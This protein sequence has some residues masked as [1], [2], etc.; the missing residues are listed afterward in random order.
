MGRLWTDN[1]LKELKVLVESGKS[2]KYLA[3]YFDRTETAI[4]LKVNRLGL[5]IQSKGRIWRQSEIKSFSND[6]LDGSVSKN[7]LIKKYNRSFPAL[8][9]KA[10]ELGLGAR[11]HNDE[12]LSINEICDE[13]NVSND[14]VS[15][16]LKLGLKYRKNRS[17]KTKYLISQDD[18]LEFLK[19]HQDLFNA[20]LI[21]N[22]LFVTEP[23]WLKEKRKKDAEFYA[24][25]LRNEYTDNDD[26]TIILLFKCGKSNK[27][28]AVDMKRTENAIAERLRMLGYSRHHWNDYEI[29]ILKENSRFMTLKELSRL[30]PLRSEKGIINKC[31]LLDLPYHLVKERCEIRVK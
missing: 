22:Y 2:R 20:S 6:W 14:R 10:F 1:E 29:D 11:P 24:T 15:H 12:F 26:K 8:K 23:N 9:K 4:D 13:M 3:N 27:E 31:E 18:L 19:Q 21:S 28:I 7:K 17:G 16:W 5:Q 30:L 25:N